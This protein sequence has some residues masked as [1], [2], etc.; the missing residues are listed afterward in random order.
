ML[1][2]SRHFTVRKHLVHGVGKNYSMTFK[3]YNHALIKMASPFCTHFYMRVII[4]T[5]TQT[6]HRL[7][8]TLKLVSSDCH[9]QCYP[10]ATV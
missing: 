3:N 4:H 6:I 8:S 2:V 7:K 1:I 10:E 5:K 9:K